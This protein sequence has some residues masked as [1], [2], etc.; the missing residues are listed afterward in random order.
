MATP[1]LHVSEAGRVLMRDVHQFSEEDVFDGGEG[2]VDFDDCHGI[3]PT[4]PRAHWRAM[5]L[6]KPASFPAA[7]RSG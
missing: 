5:A 2:W 4:A 7:L 6:S 1:M 3:I